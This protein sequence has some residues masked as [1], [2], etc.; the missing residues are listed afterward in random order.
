[1]TFD[2]HV[3]TSALLVSM[4]HVGIDVPEAI[5]SRMTD[6]ARRVPDTD[7]HIDRLY[8]FLSDLGASVLQARFSRYVVDLNRPPDDANLYPGVNTTGLCPTDTFDD[9]PIYQRGNEPSAEEITERVS[10]YWRPYHNQLEAAL[11]GIKEQHGYA[12]LWDAH[13]I[14]SE[15]PRLFDGRLPD[16]NLG[17]ASGRACPDKLATRLEIVAKS[18]GDYTSVLNGRFTGGYITRRYGAP[19]NSVIAAQ[20]ELTQT[21]YM[22]EHHPFAFSEKKANK[23]RPVLRDLLDT[24]AS[25]A[26]Q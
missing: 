9:E 7:W 3:G 18:A 22:E 21:S 19:A 14:R 20:L 23:L 15:V 10:S 1:M 26:P 5:A 25:W 6:N 12:L 13:S 11:S 8:D 4:P 16:L 2:Y 24:F 17:T